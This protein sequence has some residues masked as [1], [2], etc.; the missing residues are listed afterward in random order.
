M[1]DY[2]NNLAARS[3]GRGEQFR[4]RLPSLFEPAAERTTSSNSRYVLEDAGIHQIEDVEESDNQ[5]EQRDTPVEDAM[6]G[7]QGPQ[8]EDEPDAVQPSRMRTPAHQALESAEP[9][10][11]ARLPNRQQ[12]PGEQIKARAPGA[13]DSSGSSLERREERR[14]STSNAGAETATTKHGRSALARPAPTLGLSRDDLRAVNQGAQAKTPTGIAETSLDPPLDQGLNRDHSPFSR[15]YSSTEFESADNGRIESGPAATT[16]GEAAG[17]GERR[18]VTPASL[19]AQP[20]STI[21]VTIGRVEVRAVVNE[22]QP[23]RP[24]SVKAKP[25]MTLDEYLKQ[26]NGGQ[27]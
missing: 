7:R 27:R 18:G 26:R 14:Y 16:Y 12:P 17:Q 8:L 21:K 11:D 10:D 1:S 20:A 6:V 2:L 24:E 15:G 13:S 23:R 19:R 5:G 22:S 3:T 9:G 4:P 25:R